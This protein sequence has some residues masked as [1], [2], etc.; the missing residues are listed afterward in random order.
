MSSGG[1]GGDKGKGPKYGAPGDSEYVDGC[2]PKEKR[3][4][5]KRKREVEEAAEPPPAAAADDGT[6]AAGA[7][8]G[9]PAAG[10][11]S[12]DQCMSFAQLRAAQEAVNP[13]LW[14]LRDKLLPIANGRKRYSRTCS[15][16]SGP[17]PQKQDK[18]NRFLFEHGLREAQ[19][20]PRDW[21]YGQRD[22]NK[23]IP[24]TA[25]GLLALICTIADFGA[26]APVI[27]EKLIGL[28]SVVVFGV[29]ISNKI[30]QIF[31]QLAK[32]GYAVKAHVSLVVGRHINVMP[33]NFAGASLAIASGLF[34]ID[35][36]SGTS[37][38]RF[39]PLTERF[40]DERNVRLFL[41]TLTKQFG[42]FD[43]LARGRKS[44][45]DGV[46]RNFTP[47]SPYGHS[48]GDVRS[49]SLAGVKLGENSVYPPR[50]DRGLFQPLLQ[51]MTWSYLLCILTRLDLS[52]C[53]LTIID[54][55]AFLIALEKAEENHHT[56]NRLQRID[57]RDNPSFRSTTGIADRF[58]RNEPVI[59]TIRDLTEKMLHCVERLDFTGDLICARWEFDPVE[60]HHDS[61]L[62]Q[63]CGFLVGHT[64]IKELFLIE[65]HMQTGD[66]YALRTILEARA[67][68][69]EV[70]NAPTLTIH[71]GA[72]E[73]PADAQE[74]LGGISG[75]DVIVWT[76]QHDFIDCPCDGYW[77]PDGEGP[78]SRK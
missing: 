67:A 3:Q 60:L 78:W 39:G 1:G 14:P 46:H 18:H 15:S 34:D 58:G 2:D 47:G 72:P 19:H 38:I 53:G 9:T 63:W 41:D 65:N 36:V 13:A 66:C 49:I 37:R 32:E 68:N 48:P 52:S 76:T 17:R 20:K 45:Q 12:A 43:L 7:D 21:H 26:A 40:Q 25:F 22:A 57:L 73:L 35:H 27:L 77:F 16:S 29:M 70:R 64:H 56:R 4:R 5:Q 62:T 11:V 69:P 51:K 50:A 30:R 24:N 10:A 23:L 28:R 42:V 54:F 55:A 33:M 6:A 71:V 31:W 8:D 74:I 61:F 59:Y 44:W 75:V